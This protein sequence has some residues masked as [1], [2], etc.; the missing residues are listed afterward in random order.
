MGKRV[1][2]KSI[3]A[4]LLTWLLLLA[5]L[6]GYLWWG[7]TTVTVTDISV[8]LSD[9]PDAFSGYRI[10]QISDLH[11]A[12]FGENNEHLLVKLAQ[13]Q[14][15]IIVLTGDLFDSNHPDL[16]VAASFASNAARIAPT[17]YVTGN[18]EGFARK[19]YAQL[20]PQLLEAGVLVLENKIVE[21]ERNG[22]TVSLI[23]LHDNW[24]TSVPD[25]AAELVPSAGECSILLAHRPEF[26]DSYTKAGADLVL[27]GHVHGGQFRLPFVGGLLSPGLGFFPEY[28]AGLYKIGET[29]LIV[30]RGLGNSRI[31]VRINNRP[32]IVLAVLN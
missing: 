3:A 25:T 21:L 19:E 17:Y 27:S 16:D 28:D 1:R 7:N 20:K 14:P 4:R 12:Q 22:E 32:E 24:F 10:A 6:T 15:D 18:H 23:G 2:K 26:A 5:A 30:S 8:T 13:C 11:N 9:L 31:P 29:Q